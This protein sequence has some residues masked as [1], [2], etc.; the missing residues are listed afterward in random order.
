[1]ISEYRFEE[2]SG[3]TAADSFGSNTGTI[4]GTSYWSTGFTGNGLSCS[5]DDK[6]AWTYAG[7]RPANN[8]T[9]EAMVQVT[10]MHELDAETTTTPCCGGTSGQ[11]YVFGALSCQG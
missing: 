10:A 3:T 11:K 9:L 1:M 2:G 4:S 6:V 5:G 7:G 8:F